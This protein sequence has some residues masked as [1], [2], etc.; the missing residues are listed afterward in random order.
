M[1][2]NCDKAVPDHSI[3]SMREV[4]PLTVSESPTANPIN[5]LPKG[6]IA[7]R[8]VTV[9]PSTINLPIGMLK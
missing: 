3:L 5:L 2:S 6:D 8:A 1:I 4:I 7:E 9:V